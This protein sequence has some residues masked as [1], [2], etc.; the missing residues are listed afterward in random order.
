MI[1]INYIKKTFILQPWL[2]SKRLFLKSNPSQITYRDHKQFDSLNFNNELLKVLA[3]ENT[4]N[5]AKFDDTF[6][7]VLDKHTTFRK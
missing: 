7:K 4:N 3:I 1:V 2:Y 6:L 5:C